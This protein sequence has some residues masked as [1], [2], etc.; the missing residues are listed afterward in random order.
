MEQVL[1]PTHAFRHYGHRP[2]GMHVSCVDITGATT[3]WQVAGHSN[4]QGTA[5]PRIRNSLGTTFG[6][7]DRLAGYLRKRGPCGTAV[8]GDAVLPASQKANTD[9]RVAIVRVA[10]GDFTP[11]ANAMPSAA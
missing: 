6:G 10:Y 9:R 11:C 2:D 3:H 4:T 5:Q 1:S 8:E 7:R